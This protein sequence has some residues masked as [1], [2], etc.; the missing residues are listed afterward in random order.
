MDVIIRSTIVLAHVCKLEKQSWQLGCSSV[1][2]CLTI[3]ICIAILV[4]SRCLQGTENLR[5]V[6]L[7]S[8]Q[9]CYT[10]LFRA[11]LHTRVCSTIILEFLIRFTAS[12]LSRLLESRRFEYSIVCSYI[13]LNLAIIL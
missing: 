5:F 9:V 2:S 7:S 6:K 11:V 4:A 10:K 1:Y 8:S 13:I 12:N 3:F